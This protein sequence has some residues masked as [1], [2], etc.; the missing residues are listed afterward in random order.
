MQV[1]AK[2]QVPT[3][4]NEPPAVREE[5]SSISLTLEVV[6][7]CFSSTLDAFTIDNMATTVHAPAKVQDI[8]SKIPHDSISDLY[9]TQDGL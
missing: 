1:E 2:I 3:D 4:L 6:N 7:P 9:G 8:T 5:N